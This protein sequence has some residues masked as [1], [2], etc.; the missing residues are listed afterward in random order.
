MIYEE[1]N[2]VFQLPVQ[3]TAPAVV[4]ETPKAPVSSVAE[5]AKVE[6]A[7]KPAQIINSYSQSDNISDQAL[8]NELNAVSE[9]VLACRNQILSKIC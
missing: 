3:N 7:Q 2:S 9:E 6:P 1:D 8:F 4:F 5:A